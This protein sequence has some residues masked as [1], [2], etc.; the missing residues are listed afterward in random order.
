MKKLLIL[1]FLS[2]ILVGCANIPADGRW[3]TRGEA[4]EFI[5]Q[6]YAPLSDRPIVVRYFIPSTGNIRTMPVLMIAH[7]MGR[8]AYISMGGWMEFAERDGFILIAPE[9]C[10]EHY[11]VNDFQRGG[12]FEQQDLTQIRPRELW[13]ANKVEALF[14]DFRHY[15]RSRAL[16]YNIY[17]HSAGAQF[18]HRMLLTMPEARIGKA[19]AANAGNYTFPID[20]LH[21]QAGRVF[22]WPFSVMG[23]PF[24]TRENLEAF[25]ARHLI[26]QSGTADTLTDTDNLLRAGGAMA[27]GT[28][29]VERAH[30][31]FAASKQKAVDMNLPFNW[32]IVDVEG[33]GHWSLGMIHGTYTMMGDERI[34]SADNWT[35][36]SAYGL[37]FGNRK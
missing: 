14:D 12:I 18:V 9:F 4:A 34:V 22:G 31:F 2:C 21:N 28:M 11:S 26:I 32:Q 27:Q 10:L 29:R 1:L 17:G 19:I 15:T 25:F 16:T 36:T 37:M 24:G 30:N 20:G 6:E 13:T 35:P 33:I 5:F 8:R 23:T 3:Q 7:G